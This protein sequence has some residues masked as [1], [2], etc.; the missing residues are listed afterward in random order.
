MSKKIKLSDIKGISFNTS[1]WY[2]FYYIGA[3][4]ALLELDPNIGK[5]VKIYGC[6][7]GAFIAL[8]LLFKLNPDDILN[9]WKHIV[10]EKH[11]NESF[12]N[13]IY[14]KENC[15]HVF[16]KFFKDKIDIDV[17]NKHMNISVTKISYDFS[18]P[19]THFTNEIVSKFESENDLIKFLS[20]NKDQD[21]KDIHQLLM[22]KIEA[23]RHQSEASD[24]ITIL[25]L[26]FH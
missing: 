11:E 7:G 6:S 10:K 25:S 14:L 15:Y 13:R 26:R 23:L 8:I 24:D 22:E 20:K 21:L 3:I 18:F 19:F 1:A 9:E 17:L 4:K 12:F 5:R 2:S 16:E